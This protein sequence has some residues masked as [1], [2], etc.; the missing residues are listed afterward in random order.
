MAERPGRPAHHFTPRSGWVNDPLAVT[1]REDGYHLFFQHVPATTAWAPHCHWGHA[2]SPDL[3]SW[4]ER[5]V[6]LRPADDEVGCWS[7]CVVP[8][9]DGDLLFYTSVRD[10][11]LAVGRVRLARPRHTV[12]APGA[13]GAAEDEGTADGWE[14]WEPGEVVATAPADSGV[15]TFRD[16]VVVRD[17]DTWRMLVG[18]GL[19]AAGGRGPGTACVFG[20]A[21]PDLLSWRPTGLVAARSGAVT[22]PGWTGTTWECPQL[23]RVGDVDVL[24]VSVWD[25]EVLHHVAAAPG[26]FTDGRFTESAPWQQL[27]HGVPY[28][29]TA[30]TSRD[31]RPVLLTWLR[32]VADLEA[33]WAGALGLPLSVDVVAGRVVLDLLLDPG[34]VLVLAP[35]S[36]PVPVRD[37]DGSLVAEVA[38]DADA[39]V[40]TSSG[41]GRALRLP[42]GPGPVRV[43]VDGPVLE[44]LH[45][46]RYGALPLT[47]G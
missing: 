32:E 40:V 47:G 11:D 4:E 6:A 43:A 7:G 38:A 27:T 9:V 41:T 14:T 42:R 37:R 10:D 46:G 24:V 39:V 2:V 25:E 29:A 26:R 34:G 35:S 33:G 21:S 22:E 12:G 1:W 36:E 5:P 45:D 13:A 18:G 19:A 17:G 23:L 16:P 28:A 8:G 44:V 30:F 3:L 20:F 15:R 31:G